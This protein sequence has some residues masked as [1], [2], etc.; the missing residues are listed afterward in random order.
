M[1]TR[2]LP[3]K[4]LEAE[5]EI[6][7]ER[8]EIAKAF[9]AEGNLVFEKRGSQEDSLSFTSEQLVLLFGTIV[10][11]NHP[12]P[13]GTEQSVSFSEEDVE[14]AATLELLELR[15]VT[16]THTY[17]LRPADNGWDADYWERILKPTFQ[18]IQN[19]M[20]RQDLRNIRSGN[21]TV[22]QANQDYW[23]KIWL[24]TTQALNL[25]YESIAKNT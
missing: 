23:E 8:I 2:V 6:R 15:A 4:V 21:L 13:E 20:R 11:H 3:K 17:S 18:A 25:R 10:T 22:E 9:D 19:T 24:R 14:L 5:D 16:P 1:T 7:N 12:Y